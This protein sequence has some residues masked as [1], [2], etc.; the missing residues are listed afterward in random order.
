MYNLLLLVLIV[1]VNEFSHSH[2][3]YPI[4]SSYVPQPSTSCNQCSIRLY[5]HEIALILTSEIILPISC[6]APYPPHHLPQVV[7][8]IKEH[9]YF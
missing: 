5:T 1:H 7:S 9:S 3:S 6:L 4:F 2:Y 8:F